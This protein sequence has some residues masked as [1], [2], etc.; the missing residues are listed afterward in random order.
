VGSDLRSGPSTAWGR[1]ASRSLA[2]P[3]SSGSGPSCRMRGRQR[4][5]DHV[6]PCTELVR[7]STGRSDH[8][9]WPRSSTSS[10]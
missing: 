7:G 6:E 2:T 3:G 9:L 10:A 4:L 8:L 5:D 1:R